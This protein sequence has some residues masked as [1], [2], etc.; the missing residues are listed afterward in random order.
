VE[1]IE[2]TIIRLSIYDRFGR[3]IKRIYDLIPV[4]SELTIQRQTDGAD[5][6]NFMVTSIIMQA[7]AHVDIHVSLIDGG[8]QGSLNFQTGTILYV[9]IGYSGPQGPPGPQGIQGIQGETGPTGPQGS[10]GPQGPQGEPG[11]VI[12][13][14]TAPYPYPVVIKTTATY[15]PSWA[16]G[17]YLFTYTMTGS[18]TFSQV[19]THFSTPG[20]STYRI[21]I[22]RGDLSSATLMGETLSNAAPTS[23]Y[24]VKAV[25]V[26]TGSG[27][28]LTFL[29]GEQVVIA[30]SIGGSTS[31]AS[32]TTGPSNIALA[33]WSSGAQY[34][35]SST[36]FPPSIATITG[37]VVTTNRI[38]LDMA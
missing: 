28:S 25:T 33:A 20:S 17:T 4:N 34:T 10:T 30:Y 31:V 27:Q 23:T 21:G 8:G 22:Y 7:N 15:S 5:F 13:S 29:V 9:L 11:P 1:Q 6:Q 2:S 37:R 26:K 32:I 35:G 16:S 24:N 36:F 38:C 19:A 12:A 18:F 3:D 14:T